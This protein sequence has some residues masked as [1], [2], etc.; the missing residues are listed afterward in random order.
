MKKTIIAATL[1]AS[2]A[3][4]NAANYDVTKS[5]LETN[6]GAPALDFVIKTTLAPLSLTLDTLIEV[7]EGVVYVGDKSVD[8]A[9]YLSDATVSGATSAK[10]GIVSGTA[11][12]KV[13]IVSGAISAK[14]SIV[15]GSSYVAAKTLAGA[16]Y[17]GGKVS[18]GAAYVAEATK[19]ERAA[20][21]ANY[22]VTG[23]LV[24]L[25]AGT[26][27]EK[28]NKGVAI[29]LLSPFILVGETV[30]GSARLI[31]TGIDAILD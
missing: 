25:P 1:I 10:A 21:A 24:S 5:L 3:S 20:V 18:S 28:V 26:V 22:N 4:A 6:S 12:A 30:E 16:S 11:S 29:A 27:S 14:D 9:K 7:G 2:I 19:E 8:G 23:D 13:G 31:R 15:A 17:V